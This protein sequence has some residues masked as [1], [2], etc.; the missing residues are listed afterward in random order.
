MEILKSRGL[1][2]FVCARQTGG[3]PAT[4]EAVAQNEKN[5]PTF[6][7]FEFDFN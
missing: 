6:F 5:F 1:F 3:D 2:G 4:I 7:V